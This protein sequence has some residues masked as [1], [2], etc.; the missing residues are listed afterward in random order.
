MY[1]KVYLKINAKLNYVVTLCK[2]YYTL[3]KVLHVK[4]LF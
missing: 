3:F 4:L 2:T 1:K